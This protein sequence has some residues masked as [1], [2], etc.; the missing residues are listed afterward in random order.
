MTN[1]WYC[2]NLP[3]PCCVILLP[4]GYDDVRG[5][6]ASHHA[7][8]HTSNQQQ[9]SALEAAL[10]RP[11]TVVQGC[12]G[13]GKSMLTAKLAL[14]MGE[15]NRAHISGGHLQVLVCAPSEA[16]LDIISGNIC[17]L[18]VYKRRVLF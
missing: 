14:M 15:R 18:N 9:E 11:L 16:V 4:V 1:Y 6:L 3:E 8:F 10:S 12:P 2:H 17:F 13:A 5:L 7:T